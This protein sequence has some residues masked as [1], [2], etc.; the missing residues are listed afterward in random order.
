MLIELSYL[1]YW[2]S[3]NESLSELQYLISIFYSSTFNSLLNNRILDWSTFKAFAD[4]NSN[5]NQK[6]KFALGRVENIVGKGENAGYQHFLLFSQCFQKATSL[7][8]LRVGI[9]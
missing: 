3:L 7:G 2:K 9:V 6:L 1:P 5:L 4:D 8:S